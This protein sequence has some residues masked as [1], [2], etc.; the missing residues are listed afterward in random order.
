MRLVLLETNKTVEY[1][2]ELK[3]IAPAKGWVN[4]STGTVCFYMGIQWH[5]KQTIMSS[6]YDIHLNVCPTT[7]WSLYENSQWRI[8]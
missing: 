7:V 1:R 4:V 8:L 2:P 6:I 5:H 3:Y